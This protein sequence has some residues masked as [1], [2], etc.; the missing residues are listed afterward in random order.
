MYA[1]GK[2]QVRRPCGIIPVGTHSR[3]LPR[4]VQRGDVDSWSAE[5]CSPGRRS[6]PPPPPPP[7]GLTPTPPCVPLL[8]HVL[9]ERAPPGRCSSALSRIRL[10]GRF[11]R[12]KDEL[13]PLVDPESHSNYPLLSSCQLPTNGNKTKKTNPFPL[14]SH[15]LW[16]PQ[17]SGCGGGILLRCPRNGFHLGRFR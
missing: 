9:A 8:G 14:T 11:T 6:A 7:L 17:H 1:T 16:G 4:S 3:C 5:I 13:K 10:R 2:G 12:K 15:S